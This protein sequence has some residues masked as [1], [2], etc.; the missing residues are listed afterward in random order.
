MSEKN[1]LFFNPLIDL[2]KHTFGFILIFP[3]MSY[4]SH[5]RLKLYRN[6]K[7]I[8]SDDFH[9]IVRYYEQYENDIQ[10]LDFEEFFDCTVAYTYALFEINS[11]RKHIVMADY[12]LETIIMQNIESWNGK[13][14]YTF[15]LYNKASALYQMEQYE[16]ATHILK[17]LIKI[18]PWDTEFTKL[19]AACYHKRKPVWLSKTRSISV[20][21]FL[22]SALMIAVEI[23]V[24]PFFATQLVEVQY[25]QIGSFVLG[26]V[27]LLGGEFWHHWIGN[28]KSISF[29]S[30]R[31]LSK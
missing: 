2:I 20:F 24:K 28:Q 21:L 25:L 4:L 18:S 11:L 30:K 29:A 14:I 3:E 6:F 9:N 22:F 23:F 31:R 16:S 13:N 8:E 5:N 1:T 19:L 27:V 12:L 17:E 26:I 15:V 7:A 10:L